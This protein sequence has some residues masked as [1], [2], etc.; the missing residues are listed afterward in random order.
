MDGSDALYKIGRF[1]QSRFFGT[2]AIRKTDTV[3]IVAGSRR[4][5]TR[6]EEC[7]ARILTI[8]GMVRNHEEAALRGLDSKGY[9]SHVTLDDPAS[10][11]GS[12]RE[13]LMKK[14]WTMVTLK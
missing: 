14:T 8:A 13:E 10:L 2:A 3:E 6:L 1:A 11:D 7:R 12:L 5:R 4:V 9:V